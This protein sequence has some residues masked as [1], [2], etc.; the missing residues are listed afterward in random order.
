MFR[1]P[2]RL[3]LLISFFIYNF[4]TH[5]Q[6]IFR[7]GAALSSNPPIRFSACLGG[8]GSDEAWGEG[9][10]YFLSSA[11]KGD[12][13]M[14]RTDQRRGG[15]EDWIFKDTSHLGFPPM[16]SVSTLSFF[17]AS[18]VHSS[19]ALKLL[20]E[21][22]IVFFAG[23]DQS[24]YIDWFKNSAIEK[25]LKSR[26]EKRNI[27]IGGTSAGMAYLAGLDISARYSPPA[28]EGWNVRTSDVLSNPL[29]KF[30]DLAAANVTAPFLDSIIT[31][32]HFNERSRQG[33]LMGYMARAAF[34]HTGGFDARQIKAIG[35]DEKTAY[36]YGVDG[37]GRVYGPGDVY[38]LSVK[39]S[40]INLVKDSPLI[41]A[42][43]NGAVNAFV[44]NGKTNGEHL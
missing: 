37:I 17:K 34:D 42:S 7:T 15:Y 1:N 36:C 8:G 30:V 35:A 10:K 12:V 28:H 11:P 23:G 21:A 13:V 38:F 25:L 5:G 4:S 24:D 3:L 20:E 9:W 6:Q 39:D 19:E 14:I 33:R 18:E 40:K 16:N 31:D 22:E 26:I 43:E 44:I 41:W 32:T 27:A 2:S 29:G